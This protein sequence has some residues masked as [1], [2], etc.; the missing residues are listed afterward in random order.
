MPTL[1]IQGTVDTLFSLQEGVTN[2]G[3]LKRDHVPVKMLWYCGGHGICLD[4][5]ATAAP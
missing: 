4:N 3:I 5:P 2:Y 1:I